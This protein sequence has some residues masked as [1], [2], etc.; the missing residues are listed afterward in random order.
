MKFAATKKLIKSELPYDLGHVLNHAKRVMGDPLMPCVED[1]I[2]NIWKQH[3]R[4]LAQYGW[5][6]QNGKARRARSLEYLTCKAFGSRVISVLLAYPKKGPK[7]SWGKVQELAQSVNPR[8]NSGEYVQVVDMGKPEGGVRPISIFGKVTRANQSLARDLII[9]RHGH[10]KYEYSRKGRGR[11]KLISEIDNLN[12]NG[13]V[14]ALGILDIKNCYPSIKREAVSKVISL[15]KAIIENTI[16]ISDEVSLIMKDHSVS[17]HAVRAGLTQGSLSSVVVAGLVIE[18]C[19]DS[20]DV[21]FAASHIDDITTGHGSLAEA[22]AK[23]DTLTDVFEQKYPGS[24]LFLK[25]KKAFKI[26]ERSDILGY[27]ARPNPKLNGGG[28]RFSPSEK[29]LR[30]LYMKVAI[31]LLQIPYDEWSQILEVM[32]Y[33]WAASFQKW[34]GAPQGREFAQTVFGL[35]IEEKLWDPHDKVQ[36]LIKIGASQKEVGETAAEFASSIIPECVLVNANGF[37]DAL[38]K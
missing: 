18:P 1:A 13:G 14:R 38:S 28:L 27:W 19:L 32:T 16:F 12:R 37:C 29:A 22:K 7:I 11:E 4:K 26:G 2:R 3:S 21:K 35:M 5:A 6:G 31:K 33:A 36:Q 23:L 17:S 9:V 10:S 34:G 30:R 15:S 24:P 25:Y 8:T 20:V